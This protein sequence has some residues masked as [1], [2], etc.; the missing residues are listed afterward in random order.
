MD[1][2]GEEGLLF[3]PLLGLRVL[4]GNDGCHVRL[5]VSWATPRFDGCSFPSRQVD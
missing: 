1:P 5:E 2:S 4:D 3:S